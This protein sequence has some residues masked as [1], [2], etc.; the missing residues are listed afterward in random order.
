MIYSV[1]IID[2][3]GLTLID[4]RYAEPS[5][6]EALDPNLIS[7]ML[8]ALA[9]FCEQL[10]QDEIQTITLGNS[11]FFLLKHQGL[12]FA[13]HTDLEHSKYLSLAK[14]QRIKESFSEQR[15]QTLLTEGNE[16]IFQHY[17]PILDAL[18]GD[19]T[20]VELEIIID[21]FLAGKGI[22][23]THIRDVQKN[24]I[25]LAR[26]PQVLQPRLGEYTNLF[27][28]FF[29]YAE[30]SLNPPS[31]VEKYAIF[32]T[33]NS[34]LIG[35][36]Q[37]PLLLVALFQGD[38]DHNIMMDIIH[39]TL[40]DVLQFIADYFYTIEGA[41]PTQTALI[42]GESLESAILA[43]LLEFEDFSIFQAATSDAALAK[44]RIKTPQIVI[45]DVDDNPDADAFFDE[46]E[47][48]PQ[49][50]K[51][52]L[53]ILR[54][55][56]APAALIRTKITAFNLYKPVRREHINWIKQQLPTLQEFSNI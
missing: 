49:L 33:D 12:L 8:S 46:I 2:S 9:Q 23:G 16:E 34:W 43:R 26:S 5:G 4:R 56:G 39:G 10:I 29:E 35:F 53:I 20:A 25:V 55:K 44:M 3:A 36:K 1:R 24:E 41:K 47:S 32:Q 21:Y 22:I 17:I 27:Q 52:P 7:G 50:A 18:L 11:Q 19:R 51:I 40:G 48:D 31:S 37:E 38:L 30:R 14:L 45:Y 28:V 6:D 15:P 42:I 13:M 54:G